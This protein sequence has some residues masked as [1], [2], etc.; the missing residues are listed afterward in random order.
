MESGR[1]A[2]FAG[3]MGELIEENKKSKKFMTVK[4]AESKKDKLIG[5]KESVDKSIEELDLDRQ[6]KIDTGKYI[7]TRV[8][9]QRKKEMLALEEYIDSLK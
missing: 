7:D 3:I 8:I 6:K 5:E 2:G 1:N 4:M 9:N